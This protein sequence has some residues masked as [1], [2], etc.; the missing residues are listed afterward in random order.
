MINI[1]YNIVIN[2]FKA[3]DMNNIDN[4]LIFVEKKEDYDSE[5]Q[6]LLKEFKNKVI[7][8]YKGYQPLSSF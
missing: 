5:S 8:K 6:H 4:Q 7:K 1:K 2:C 3:V